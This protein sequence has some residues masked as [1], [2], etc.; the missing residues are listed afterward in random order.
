MASQPGNSPKVP[1]QNDLYTVLVIVAA[2]LLLG[3]IIFLLF[4]S[5]QLFGWPWEMA[6]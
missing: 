2:A 6:G 1:A 4:R 5:V 3:G